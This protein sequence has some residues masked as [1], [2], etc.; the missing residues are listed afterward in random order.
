MLKLFLAVAVL[1]LFLYGIAI[2]VRRAIAAKGEIPYRRMPA[3]YVATWF[4]LALF[5]IGYQH[6]MS[7]GSAALSGE[8]IIEVITAALFAAAFWGWIFWRFVGLYRAF[9]NL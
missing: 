1:V 3:R 2:V 8:M 4:V 9:P 5:G 6:Y 7:Y